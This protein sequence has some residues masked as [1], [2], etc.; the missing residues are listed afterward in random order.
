MIDLE[1]VSFSDIDR[2]SRPIVL[3]GSGNITKKTLRRIEDDSVSF[4]ADNS[5]NIQ[6]ETYEGYDIRPPDEITADHFVIITSTAIVDISEQLKGFGFEPQDDFVVS[7]VLNDRIA[8]SELEHLETEFYFTSGA[9]SGTDR[10][11]KYGNNKYPGGL[12][13]CDIKGL[14]YDYEQIYEGPC[15]GSIRYEGSLLFIDTDTGLMKYDAGTITQLAELPSN[16]RPH[17]LSYNS[18]DGH[19]YVACSYLDSILRLDESF[20][21]VDEYTISDKIEYTGEAMHHCNDCLAVDNSLYVTMFSSSG[22]WKND[23]FDGCLAEFNID[24][25]DR[26]ND[27]RADLW[28]PHNVDLING[29][30]HVLDSLTGELRYNNL[31]VQGSFPA[32]SRG[33]DYHEGRY[34]VGQ[35]KNRNHSKVIGAKKTVS[36]D[37]GVVIFDPELQISRFLHFPNIAGIHSITC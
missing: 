26:R 1:T 9:V 29:S 22:N 5:E 19:F 8:I 37:C 33:L 18:A 35:S 7:P 3:F 17:G 28:M 34:F 27:I 10:L 13:K 11:S 25:G 31:T 6:G 24:T 23:S 36:I 20:E 14:E 2:T 15:Y 16:S 21:I 32:F 4:I 30:L 12:F